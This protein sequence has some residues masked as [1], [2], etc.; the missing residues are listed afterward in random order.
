[1]NKTVIKDILYCLVKHGLRQTI[2]DI[3]HPPIEEQ[4]MQKWLGP[5]YSTN[6]GDADKIFRDTIGFKWGLINDSNS[7]TIQGHNYNAEN[8]AKIYENA[9]LI[10]DKVL[11]LNF[12]KETT[13]PGK[14]KIKLCDFSSYNPDTDALLVKTN[15]IFT[16]APN[17]A[18]GKPSL[19]ATKELSN[20]HIFKVTALKNCIKSC[21]MKIKHNGYVLFPHLGAGVN[22]CFIVD[23]QNSYFTN[24]D[25]FQNN[26]KRSDSRYTEF[27]TLNQDNFFEIVKIVCNELTHHFKEHNITNLEINVIF[28]DQDV[29]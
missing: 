11:N 1:M 23:N 28:R 14:K 2:I 20:T 4:I 8:D 16:F 18:T 5:M 27:M 7:F 21:L 12:C 9:Y 29:R 3:K 22:K 15:L 17:Y 25:E 26:R 24:F 10:E 6:H 19:N 13:T